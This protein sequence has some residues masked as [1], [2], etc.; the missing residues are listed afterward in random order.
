MAIRPTHRQ[1]EYLVAVGETG[2]FGEAARQ[3]HVSQ[4]TLS[5]QLQ[6]LED[7]LQAKLIDRA[8]GGA[9]PTPLG[10]TIIGLSR[11]IL[12]TLD[13]IQHVTN[14]AAENLGGLI[15]L[16]VVPTFGPYF[17]PHVLPRLHKHYPGL[18]L[19][20]REERPHDLEQSILAGTLDCA[21]TPRPVS[22]KRLVYHDLITEH[23]QLG[24]PAEHPLAAHDTI[25]PDMLRGERMLTL[26]S[27]HQLNR[28]VQAF[29]E[30]SGALL[31]EGYE[32]TS[33]DAIRQMV[34]IGMG[35]SLFPEYYIKSEFPKENSVV[36]RDVTGWS[37]TRTI[38]LIWRE[39]SVRTPQYHRFGEECEHAMIDADSEV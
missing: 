30:S 7:R 20:I 18:E 13:E 22:T 28:N 19:Y 11:S 6:L 17:L 36:L 8:P 27:D 16:G 14:N 23:L 12:S 9:R 38:G 24:L 2:H 3:C 25:S 39:G 1:L 31:H 37:L 5:M 21:L 4:P 33:L 15:R 10:E 29:C 26:G 32:G 35:L 34:S